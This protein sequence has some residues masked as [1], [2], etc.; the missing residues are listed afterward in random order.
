MR[1]RPGITGTTMVVALLA[2][3][4][5]LGACSTY[6][7]HSS[8]MHSSISLKAG[9]IRRGGIAFITPSTA[10]GHEQDKQALALAF[11]DVLIAERPQYRV[12][13]L[14]RT[15]S[16]INRAGLAA[17]YKKMYQD[18]QDTGIFD[19][20]TLQ[21]IGR[22]IGT[23]YLAQLKLAGF[24][25]GSNERFGTLGLRIF[26]TLYANIR[27]FLQIW[28]SKNGTIAWEGAEELNYA[29]DTDRE[30][31]VTFRKVVED[32]ARR[33]IAKMPP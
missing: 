27:L 5:L 29:Y 12:V 32:A 1:R 9:D 25:Q 17:Q 6:Q 3:L 7:V 23:R 2:A 33:L 11:G 24:R 26:Q 10:T 13:T 19:R 4:G 28:D 14:A 15:L 22:A 30:K 20:C 21:K 16:D 8:E 18:Y 31:P